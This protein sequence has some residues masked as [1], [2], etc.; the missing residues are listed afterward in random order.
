[1]TTGNIY[2]YSDNL[3][4]FLDYPSIDLEFQKLISK[5]NFKIDSKEGSGL[6]IVVVSCDLEY[7]RIYGVEFINSFYKFNKLIIKKNRMMKSSS[8]AENR[9][10]EK[11]I[12]FF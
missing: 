8:E 9:Y 11:K 10:H 3:A 5:Y 7:F 1:M 6:T 4:N 2:S 12:I